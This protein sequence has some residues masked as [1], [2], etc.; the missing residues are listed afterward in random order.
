[1]DSSTSI[2]YCLHGNSTSSSI[3]FLRGVKYAPQAELRIRMFLQDPDPYMVT[4]LDGNSEISA[5]GGS[6]PCYLNC[7]RHLTGS[8]ADG[9]PIFYSET[10][11]YHEKK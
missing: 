10:P 5:H 6:T 3:E 11:I 4:I 2:M 9:N 8:K 1:M 7:S